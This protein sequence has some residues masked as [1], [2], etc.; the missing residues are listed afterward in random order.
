M[1]NNE[2][3]FTLIELL[4][5][6][7]VLAIIASFAIPGFGSL[8]EGNRLA[9]NSN[10]VISSIRLAR[11]EALKRGEAVTF[12]TDGGMESGWCV[13]RGDASANCNQNANLIRSFDPGRG[14][15]FVASTGDLTFDRRGFLIPQNGQT[16]TVRPDD[17]VAGEGRLTM[18][19]ISPVGR[20]DITNGVCP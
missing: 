20:T 15:T 16:I 4:I 2:K 6:M 10:L 8:I 1:A 18:I 17:C 13:H 12:S 11:S 9:S 5:T 14:L 7:V 19:S 3:G